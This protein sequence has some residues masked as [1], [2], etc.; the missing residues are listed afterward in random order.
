MNKCSC[1]L[2]NKCNSDYA[3]GLKCDGIKQP[4]GCPYI[5]EKKKGD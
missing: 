3:R 4:I 2:D 1:L 5:F